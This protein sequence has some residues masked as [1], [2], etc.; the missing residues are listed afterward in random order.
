MQ[1]GLYMEI[2]KNMTIGELIEKAPEKL[3]ILQRAGMHCLRMSSIT[4]RNT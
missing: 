4:R 2:N 1:G 3:E